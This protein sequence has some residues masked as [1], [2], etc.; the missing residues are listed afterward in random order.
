[1]LGMR[2]WMKTHAEELDPR[3]TFFV[4]VDSIAAGAV[5]HVT[6]EGFALLYRHDPSLVRICERLGSKPHVWR[7]GTDG[8][9]AAMQ[10]FPSVTLCGADERGRVPNHRRTSDTVANVVE[11]DFGEAVDFVEELVR[12]IDDIGARRV[13]ADQAPVR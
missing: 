12:R 7:T 6:G 9:I 8:V 5:H 13:A 4:H 1:M 2:Q 11:G 3:R 10:G